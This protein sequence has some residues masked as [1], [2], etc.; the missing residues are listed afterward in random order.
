MSKIIVFSGSPRKNGYTSKLIAQVISGAKSKGAEVKIYDLNA[1]DIKG[2]KGCFYCR[3]HEGCATKDYLYTMYDD[4][5]NADGIIFGSP[6][7]FFQITGQAKIWLDRM[8]PMIDIPEEVKPQLPGEEPE[9][10]PRFPGKKIVTVYTQGNPDKD[11]FKSSIE[12]TNRFFSIFGWNL[13]N[14]LLCYGTINPNFA[15]SESLL[16]EAYKAGEDLVS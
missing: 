2:C 1:D 12:E 16:D 11:M 15:I 10:K 14:S 6:I 13:V 7:Y 3:N 9:F 4:I 8:Y 5:K